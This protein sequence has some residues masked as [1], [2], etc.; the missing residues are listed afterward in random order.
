MKN[1]IKKTRLIY[2]KNYRKNKKNI[3]NRIYKEEHKEEIKEYRIL[4]KNVFKEKRKQ[5]KIQ[6]FNI[7]GGCK[8]AICGD[9]EI[10]HLTIDHIDKTG[11]LDKKKNLYSERIYNYIIKD[12]LNK[13]QLSNLRVLYWN[14]N[15]SRKRIYLTLTHK[16]QSYQQ[17]Y[18]AKLWKEAYEFF[19]PC[20]TC[21]DTELKHLTISHIHND[22]AERRRNGEKFGIS[23]IKQFRKQKWPE[24]L[25]EDFCLECF[26]C[27]CRRKT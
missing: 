8:C 1:N 24:S 23:L 9:E 21:G 14:C 17:R 25:K 6:T 12:K 11:Y 13:K 27:N 16:E 22:G 19:G 20:K 3:K 2:K 26:N 15:C 5:I 4:N 10:N 18:N 7:L